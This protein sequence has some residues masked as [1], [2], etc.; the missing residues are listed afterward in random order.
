MVMRLQDHYQVVQFIESPNKEAAE[1]A[2]QEA[3][4]QWPVLAM[5]AGKTY[6]KQSTSNDFG[7][8]DRYWHQNRAILDRP[9]PMPRWSDCHP[10]IRAIRKAPERLKI[11]R[12]W[13]SLAVLLDGANE[14]G[15]ETLVLSTPMCGKFYD[16]WGVHAA[17]RRVYYDRLEQVAG[18]RA[19]CLLDFRDHEN[20]LDFASDAASHLSSLG[21][22]YY[23][24][25]LDAF[26]NCGEKSEFARTT[27]AFSRTV[28]Q[29]AMREE[30]A[31]KPG[32]AAAPGFQGTLDRADLERIAGW[33]WDANHPDQ[34]IRVEILEG[35][36]LI[37][38]VTADAFRPGLLEAGKGDGC[39]SFALATPRG[40][41]D[42]RQHR[43]SARVTGQA[44]ELNQSP[45]TLEA[46]P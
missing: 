23:A 41:R 11:T 35:G 4:I 25:A 8:S 24:Q 22:I 16:F 26:R 28:N 30:Q 45:R 42:G 39:H 7:F 20:D 27:D 46:R 34:R 36:H 14:L 19:T 10:I 5:R 31:P 12:E 6:R 3:D 2:R 15:A 21:W 33:A 29:S 1:P 40:L 13:D 37:A 44:K 18:G 9:D 38:A 32:A 17:D 43:I